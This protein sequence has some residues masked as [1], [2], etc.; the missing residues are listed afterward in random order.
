LAA[1]VVKTIADRQ[2]GFDD[3]LEAPDKHRAW[4][5]DGELHRRRVRRA[6]PR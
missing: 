5:A 3:V 4:I 2:E 6:G 1:K